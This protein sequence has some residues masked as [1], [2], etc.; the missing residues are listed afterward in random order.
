ME[1]GRG[2]FVIRSAA[3]VIAAI[4]ALHRADAEGVLA[5]D[6]DGTLW[7]GDVGEDVFHRAIAEGFLQD[8]ARA[9]LVREAEAHG[10]AA[11][12]SP[13]AVAQR[14]FDAYL[15][16]RYPERDVCAMMTWCYA[17]AR[18]SEL[19]G[20]TRAAFERSGLAGRLNRELEPI[21]SFA[22]R[23]GLRVAVV[24]ASPQPIVELAAELW[25]IPHSDIAASRPALEGDV[26]LPRLAAP[27]PYAEAKV[28]ALDALVGAHHLLASFGDNVFDVELLTAARLGVA[29]RP[30][31]ALQSRLSELPGIVVLQSD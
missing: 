4:G 24:S 5:F 13:S 7:S 23:E 18:V 20:L 9:A 28:S 29:V 3:Q 10:I 12:G 16:R 6:G 15:A 2:G 8:S 1:G 27:V 19:A 14:L 31:P 11:D 30:K 22:R 25:E 21:V 26:I 17:G